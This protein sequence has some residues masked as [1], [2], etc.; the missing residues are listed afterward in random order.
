MTFE[1]VPPEHSPYTTIK[2]V[3]QIYVLGIYRMSKYDLL[4]LS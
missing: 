4:Q 1:Y 3:Y 2:R